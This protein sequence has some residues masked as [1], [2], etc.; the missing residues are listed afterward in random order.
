MRTKANERGNKM[1]Y[2]KITVNGK[3][4]EVQV[5]DMNVSSNRAA[6]SV[7]ADSRP[8]PKAQAAPA[9]AP[10][11]APTAAPQAPA[12]PKAAA[13]AGPGSVTAPL[14]GTILSIAVKEGDE[15]KAGQ[16]ILLLEAMKME[17]E[18]V[19]PRAGT[20]ASIA[21]SV[22]LAVNTGDVLVELS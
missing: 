13:P 14:P 8:A 19:A 9:A 3:T 20:V 6:S 2:Y 7:G 21:V 17:N 4:Y 12:A 1:K 16:I 11:P 15:V 10:A 22:G 18:I 5:E